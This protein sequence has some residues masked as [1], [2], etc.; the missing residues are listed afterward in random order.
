[1]RL[2]Y[3]TYKYSEGNYICTMFKFDNNMGFI[4]LDPPRMTAFIAP[5]VEQAT[6][7]GTITEALPTVFSAKV[8][9]GNRCGKVVQE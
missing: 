6:R 9:K 5:I 1:M 3:A 7:A 4:Y 8:W 2:L